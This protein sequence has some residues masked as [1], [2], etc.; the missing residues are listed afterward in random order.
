MLRCCVALT[1]RSIAVA[2]DCSIYVKNAPSYAGIG[3]GGEGFTAWTIAGPTGE[4][5]TTA[6]TF[7][8]VRRCT[9]KDHFRIV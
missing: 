4:G 6:R 5:L 7:S 1:S 3:M 2:C 8:R 9:L